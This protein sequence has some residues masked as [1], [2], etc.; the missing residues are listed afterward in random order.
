[1]TPEIIA[2]LVIV[3]VLAFVLL[4][5]CACALFPTSGPLLRVGAAI[6]GEIAD[7]VAALE[8]LRAQRVASSPA[9]KEKDDEIW[10][11]AQPAVLSNGQPN[12]QAIRSVRD[13]IGAHPN[14]ASSTLNIRGIVGLSLQRSGI[15]S[16]TLNSS[17][18]R[19]RDSPH[20]KSLGAVSAPLYVSG[21][22]QRSSAVALKGGSQASV[23]TLS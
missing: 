5:G 2:L 8:R 13:S 15:D 7:H 17:S 10:T 4:G 9:T 21:L 6:D 19:R 18:V 20:T 23:F 12:D 22:Q 3:G 1:M 11:D 16:C 14:V